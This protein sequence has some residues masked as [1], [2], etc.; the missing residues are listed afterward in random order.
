MLAIS[1][2]AKPQECW[3]SYIRKPFHGI[4]NFAMVIL[5]ELSTAR[6]LIR[7]FRLSDTDSFTGF[8]TNELITCNLAF[9]DSV[10]NEKGAIAILEQTV[11]AYDSEQPLMAYAIEYKANGAFI[12]ACGMTIL[13][14]VEIEVF[15]AFIPGYWA[16]GLATEVLSALTKL[17]RESY[18]FKK[19][20][21]FITQ[22]NLASKRV[23][24]KNGY[25]DAGLVYKE[26]FRDQVSDYVLSL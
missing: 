7:R 10:K 4:N 20:H 17:I 2:K 18:R 22:G 11:S 16:K 1:A 6:T 13:S 14:P 12:G 15:Y 26:G 5:N 9:D 3:W 25:N 21:A 24:E 19:V 23:A 8:M